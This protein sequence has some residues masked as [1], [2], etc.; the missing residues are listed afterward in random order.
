MEF[1]EVVR[2]RRMS[3]DFND[4]LISH[5]LIDELLDAV[6]Y[7]PSAGFTQGF[8][9]LVLT[10]EN[11]RFS[12]FKITSDELWLESSDSKMIT[13]APVIII[14][15]CLKSEYINRYSQTDKLISHNN[16]NF[17][18]VQGTAFWITDLSF[19]TM[20]LLLNAENLGLGALFFA[21]HNNLDKL[22]S[23]FN[24]DGDADLIGAVAVGYKS[25][26]NRQTAR[27]KLKKSEII[28][29]NSWN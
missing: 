12:F 8:R 18:E 1:D 15:F 6:R 26:V 5:A 27:T 9:F 23:H 10:E 13:N 3:R 21:I 29:F 25:G 2:N 11:A 20:I 28:K 16:E 4:T 7:S 14:P 24:I 19:A 22:K 17:M